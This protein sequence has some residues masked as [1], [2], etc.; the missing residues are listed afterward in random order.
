[1]M[2]TGIGWFALC[3]A[4]ATAG[5]AAQPNVNA[6]ERAADAGDKMVCKKFLETGSL[7]RGQRVCKTKREWERA[8]DQMRESRPQSGCAGGDPSK[9]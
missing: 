8:R 2:R 6:D 4:A 9:C 1:M 3:L 7:V 5:A